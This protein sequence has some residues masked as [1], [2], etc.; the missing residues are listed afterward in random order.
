M[1]SLVYLYII[2]SNR[3]DGLPGKA[4]LEEHVWSQY[5][6]ASCILYIPQTFFV[7]LLA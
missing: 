1:F 3:A 7:T 6:Q 2:G 5:P 4:R